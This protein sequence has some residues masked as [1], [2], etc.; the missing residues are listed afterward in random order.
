MFIALLQFA[1]EGAV[2]EEEFQM[3]KGELRFQFLFS[4]FL[5]PISY[6]FQTKSRMHSFACSKTSV[7]PVNKVNPSP[8]L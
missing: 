3:I 5:V 6:R 2:N 1:L 4:L 7:E 8:E